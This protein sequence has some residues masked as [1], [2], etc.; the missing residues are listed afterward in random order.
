MTAGVYDPVPEGLVGGTKKRVNVMFDPVAH[1]E[2]QRAGNVSAYISEVV[3]QRSQ[4]WHAAL[5]L[6]HEEGW[7][8]RKLRDAL[9]GLVPPAF[10]RRP[11]A[12]VRANAGAV[13]ESVARAMIVLARELRAG[14]EEAAKR[15]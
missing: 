15:L 10:P 11:T 9:E 3:R 7:K 6:L 5:E 13:S 4:E 1:A 8:G 2:A 14:N 12:V